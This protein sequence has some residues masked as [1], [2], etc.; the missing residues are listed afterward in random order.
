MRR[1]NHFVVVGL[2][3][4]Q[5]L[6]LQ[7]QVNKEPKI[8]KLSNAQLK[9]F[10]GVYDG[11]LKA[12]ITLSN[13][14]LQAESPTVNLPKTNIFPSDDHHL[15]LKIMDAK[16][17]FV[18]G[19]DG[20]FETVI[21]D[22][23]GEH[24]ELKRVIIN[25][26]NFYRNVI[27]MKSVNIQAFLHI[28]GIKQYITIKGQDNSKPLLLFLHGGPGGAVTEHADGFTDKLQKEFIVVQWD[29]RESGTTLALN[30]SPVPLNVKLFQNDT[31]DLIDSLLKQF[32]KKKIY[33]VGHSWGTSLGFYIADKYPQLLYAFIAISPVINQLESEQ[34]SLDMLKAK[35][36]Q[37]NN[38]V[39]TKELATVKIPFENPD[40]LYYHRKWLFA[41]SGQEI[42]DT[43]SLRDFITTWSAT[44]F[45]VGMESFKVNLIRELPS[46]KCP[47]YFFVGRKDYQTNF[48]ISER[49]LKKLKAP[50]KRLF[51]FENSGHGIPDTEPVLMQDIIIGKIL[52]ETGL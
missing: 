47:V 7:A 38:T 26:I 9:K 33:L 8:T 2:L 27:N 34:L 16:F 35:A 23:E 48:T 49:Y 36:K 44:W 52:P 4:V 29:Q 12:I 20:N 19:P 25:D 24:Y 50:K 21:A 18:E 22:D 15:F 45:K 30:H 31:H 43:A 28:G 11:K 10:T 14:Q 39:E 32:H 37:T 6:P 41:F 46:I 13:G 3:L 42:G 40:Q 51:W 1:L 5:F 17:E